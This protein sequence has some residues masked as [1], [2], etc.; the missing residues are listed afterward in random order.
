MMVELAR[1][2]ESNPILRPGDVK[3]SRAGW[4]V[5]CLLNPGAFRYQGRVGL[6]LRVAERPVQEAG[7]VSTPVLDPA[8][9]E[10]VRI[11]RFKTDDP[12]LGYPDP[13]IFRY[14]GLTYLTTLS[15]LRLAWS[16]DGVRFV[17]EDVPTIIGHGVHETFGVE[18]CRV[19]R[20]GERYYL[21]YT[22]VSECG[23]AVG[24][25][26][27]ADWKVFEREGIIIPPH[28]KDCAVF[29]DKID[30]E[31]FCLHRPTGVDLGG[32]YIWMARS[33]DGLHW[34]D[35]RC[36]AKTRRDSWDSQRVGAGAAPIHTDRGW[37]AIYH[38]ADSG[39]V[40]RLGALLMDRDDPY[41]VIARSVEPVMAPSAEYER[42]GF[43][44]GVV[45]CNG[46]IVEG[47]Q[48][49]IYY[50]AA[51]TVVCGARLSVREVLATL[52]SGNAAL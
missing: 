40:Y 7:W 17:A 28:N 34:G 6:L 14:D 10:G 35:H 51:D 1:R 48:L 38:G 33:P 29:E 24:M 23:V 39:N 4:T 22:A 9:A 2:F 49:T 19:A 52:G 13:R 12:R 47:D 46:Q 36:I 18:D 37:L 31:Y 27:T 20:I 43:V 32:N 44:G 45:F 50:G 26:Q 25:I 15:H 5:E 21:T 8:S 42:K 16:D 41:R 30:G 11:V 3:T